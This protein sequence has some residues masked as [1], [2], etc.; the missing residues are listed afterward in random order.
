VWSGFDASLPTQSARTLTLW[1]IMLVI[2]QPIG[3][4]L[5]FVCVLFY[6]LSRQRC[7]EIR[8]QLDQRSQRSG[9]S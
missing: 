1:I 7:R 4:L 6:P 8:V 9:Q 2:T 5:G 3:F